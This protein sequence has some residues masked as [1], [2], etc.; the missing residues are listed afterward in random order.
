LCLL[1][2]RLERGA[3][4]WPQSGTTLMSLSPA[5]LAML[6]EGCEWRAPVQSLRPTLAG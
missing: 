4:A 6:L 2:R 5:Q 3:F 1:T